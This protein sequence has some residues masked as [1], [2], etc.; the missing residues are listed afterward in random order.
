MLTY[1]KFTADF[2]GERIVKIGQ[3]S[4][5]LRAGVHCKAAGF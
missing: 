1:Y 5:K 3:H 2:E 4:A